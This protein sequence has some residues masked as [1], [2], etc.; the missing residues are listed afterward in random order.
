MLVLKPCGSTV[1][2][3]VAEWLATFVAAFVVT[4]GGPVTLS[5]AKV[6]SAP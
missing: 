2:S 6:W 3:S 5:V 4:T 1:L